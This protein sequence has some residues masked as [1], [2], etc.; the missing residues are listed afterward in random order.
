MASEKD[1]RLQSSLKTA[2]GAFDQAVAVSQDA[3]NDGLYYLFDKYEDLQK[4]K[5]NKKKF[6][7]ID[8]MMDHAEVSLPVKSSSYRTLVFYCIFQTGKL[9]LT[10][11]D[12]NDKK[13][14]DLAD[15][16]FA[17]EVDYT[18]LDVPSDTTEHQEA[19]KQMNQ[20]G[21]YSIKRLFLD[22]KTHKIRNFNKDLSDFKG[23]NWDSEDLQSFL[24]LITFWGDPEKGVMK[25]KQKSTL[26]YFL[27][28][29]K[30]ETVNPPAPTFPPTSVKHQHYKYI[31]PGKQTPDE[32]P[33][34]GK[35]NMLLYLE[36][37]QNRS[38]PSEDIL[39]YSGNFVTP[40][41]KG[42]TCISRDIFWDSYLLRNPSLSGPYGPQ[43]PLLR[44][45]NRHV[46]AW[47]GEFH[48]WA[49][50]YS[51]DLSWSYGFG[52]TRWEPSRSPDY[53]A[54]KK[55]S[56]NKWE[57][58][59]K[60][61]KSGHDEGIWPVRL[62]AKASSDTLNEL[63]FD[64]GSNKIHLEGC[65]KVWAE[66]KRSDFQNIE[67]KGGVAIN[68]AL[69]ITIDSVSEG[70][71]KL[72]MNLPANPKDIFHTTALTK[73][74]ATE[75]EETQDEAEPAENEPAE[76]TPKTG[77]TGKISVH[78]MT[79]AANDAAAKLDFKSVTSNLQTALENSARFV[80]PGGRQF[81]Y[82]NAVFGNNGDLLVE[83]KYKS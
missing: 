7:R 18:T 64:P 35:N 63:R 1:K 38:F 34:D 29:A 11:D 54:W 26:G 49:K 6:G 51:T 14:I 72:N 83:A 56:A 46:Y 22:F 78:D 77:K 81:F 52:H 44:E 58:K 67:E 45:F 12:G 13:P 79:E 28:T 66:M 71:L 74:F 53:F 76:S 16:R 43:P 57:W 37:T 50:N 70:G 17:F 82:N 32:G 75:A 36:M 68:W 62:D 19:K 20:P 42:T 27:T 33:K 59:N 60:D 25:D 15:W 30:P 41:M 24:S 2:T 31:A 23:H 39:E 80:L 73:P 61:K 48:V 47:L 4:M 40:G 8:A 3:L 55:V 69:D 5:V 65:S 10:D 21:D 9:V